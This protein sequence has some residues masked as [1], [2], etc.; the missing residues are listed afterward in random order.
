[1]AKECIVEG[2]HYPIFG[3][4]LCKFHQWKR[5][6]KKPT[7]NKPKKRISPISENRAKQLAIYRP[8]RDEYMKNHPVCEVDGCN[9]PSN[10]LHHKNKRNGNRVYDEKY[11]MAICRSHHTQIDED[12]VW[13]RENGYLI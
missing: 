13:A 4:K 12:T 8:K 1:M 6:D 7:K 5:T 2:C 9:N 10:D 3:G 11:F